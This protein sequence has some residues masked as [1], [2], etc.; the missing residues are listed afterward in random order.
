MNASTLH[1]I[2]QH[3]EER[4]WQIKQERLPY[5]QIYCQEHAPWISPVG[6]DIGICVMES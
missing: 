1:N 4:M 2:A 5:M 6:G 3:I